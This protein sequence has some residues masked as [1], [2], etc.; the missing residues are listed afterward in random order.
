MDAADVFDVL[1]NKLILVETNMIIT[2]S[3]ARQKQRDSFYKRK[4][5]FFFGII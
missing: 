5:R 4:G 1:C 2:N 3:E